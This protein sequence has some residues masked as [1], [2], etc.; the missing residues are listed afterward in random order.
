MTSQLQVFTAHV[1][2]RDPDRVDVTR[3]SGGVAGLPFAPSWRILMPAIDA[4]RQA[5]RL[6]AAARAEELLDAPDRCDEWALAE[7]AARIVGEAWAVYEPAYLAEMR[8]SYRE[9]RAAWD[10]LLARRRVVLVCYC[11]TRERCHRG[12]L[13]GRILP[14]F[15]ATDHGEIDAHGHA[16]ARGE[17]GQR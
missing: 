11:P 4:R 2:T 15:G 3:K 9:N 12:L 10:A 6:M 13:A 17:P 7:E 14:A 1:S 16:V 8:V 5:E